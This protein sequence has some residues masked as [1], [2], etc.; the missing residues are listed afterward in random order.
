MGITTIGVSIVRDYT[1]KVQPPRT[2][3]LRWPF[4]HPFGEPHHIAQQRAVLREMFK[5]VEA[6]EQP[7]TIID[8]PYRWR[9]E[10]YP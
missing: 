6:I 2:V 9:R 10:R 7:G 8:L 5:A 4:G 3:F 1:E